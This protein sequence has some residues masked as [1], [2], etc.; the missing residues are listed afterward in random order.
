M[1]PISCHTQRTTGVQLALAMFAITLSL[2]TLPT[3]AQTIHDSGSPGVYM[4]AANSSQIRT[5]AQDAP[6]GLVTIFSNLGPKTNAFTSGGWFV[7]GPNFSGGK[8]S[9]GLPFSPKLN[10][11]VTQVQV[12]IQYNASGANQV[13]LSVYSDHAGLPGT[14]V[15]GPITITHLSNCCVCC[16]LTIGNFS[17]AVPLVGGTKYWLVADTPSSGTGSDFKG[18][19]NWIPPSATMKVGLNHSGWTSFG[20]N[21]QEPAGGIFGTVP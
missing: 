2:A 12:A 6:A 20:A 18:V 8:Q 10:S 9:V 11:H 1:K 4:P 17:P 3:Q 19:W 7:L 16:T 15:G 14:L 21:I 5:P 13:N